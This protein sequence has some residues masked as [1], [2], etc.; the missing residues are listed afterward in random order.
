[1]SRF[2]FLFLSQCIICLGQ[3][4]V[5][6]NSFGYPI[7]DLNAYPAEFIK[8]TT[9]KNGVIQ[10]FTYNLDTVK[11]EHSTVLTDENGEK[12]SERI[13]GYYPNGEMKFNKRI[14]YAK[15]EFKET[16]Y[17]EDGSLKS[18]I[19]SSSME[20]LSETYYGVDGVVIDKPLMKTLNQKEERKAGI[21]FW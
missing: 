9:Q 21:I 11:V 12:I 16:N 14:D 3:E 17:Y 15:D 2:L 6:L 20:I 1:M 19:I 18:E 7:V 4:V 13:L 5:Y 8:V 10:S